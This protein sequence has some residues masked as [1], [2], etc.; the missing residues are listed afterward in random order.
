MIGTVT[1]R[2]LLD[3]Y[4]REIHDCFNQAGIPI[5]D[6]EHLLLKQYFDAGIALRLVEAKPLT[7]TAHEDVV[8]GVGYSAVTKPPNSNH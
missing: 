2:Q 8:T 4:E 5:D 7:K 1:E 3:L 6:F